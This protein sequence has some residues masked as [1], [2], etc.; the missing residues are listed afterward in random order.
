MKDY[1]KLLNKIKKL[2]EFSVENS[3][4]KTTIK[5]IH[6]E[7]GNMYS[8]HPGEAGVFP[9]KKWINLFVKNKI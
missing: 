2:D 6:K 5:I 4:R 3:R 7:S 1:D 8:S 9:L